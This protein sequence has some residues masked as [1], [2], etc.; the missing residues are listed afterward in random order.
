M[1]KVVKEHMGLFKPTN[2]TPPA[3]LDL[4]NPKHLHYLLKSREN[5]RFQV[6]KFSH[7]LATVGIQSPDF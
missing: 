6:F 2:L 5:I 4:D 3:S 7:I 1:Q